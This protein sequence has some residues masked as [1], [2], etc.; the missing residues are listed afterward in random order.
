M[1][2]NSSFGERLSH[3]GANHSRALVWVKTEQMEAWACAACTWA[4]LPSGPPLGKNI[5]EMIQN[6]E[7]QRDK[8]FTSHACVQHPKHKAI[9]DRSSFS[10]QK[11]V[12][13]TTR[14]KAQSMSAKA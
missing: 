2:T 6:Y 9:Q 13:C 11:T 3:S 7:L 14:T 10:Y 4:F 1:K 5:E 8:E 12:E